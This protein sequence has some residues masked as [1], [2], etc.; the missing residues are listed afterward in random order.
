MEKYLDNT[1]DEVGCRKITSFLMSKK[2]IFNWNQF[3][4]KLN[5]TNLTY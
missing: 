3:L 5:L 2:T 4:N 1:A